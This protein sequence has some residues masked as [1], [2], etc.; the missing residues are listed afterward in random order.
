MNINFYKIHF[1]KTGVIYG[2]L[3][4][5]VMW[6]SHLWKYLMHWNLEFPELLEGVPGGPE[7]QNWIF[8]DQI[9]SRKTLKISCLLLKWKYDFRGKRGLD[10]LKYSRL[11]NY[12]IHSRGLNLVLHALFQL[13][14]INC[15]LTAFETLR[16]TLNDPTV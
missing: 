5:K 13:T 6:P 4:L 3:L 2:W 14:D 11:L 16:V 12:T 8:V 10:P 15:Q 9:L 7:G 1:T